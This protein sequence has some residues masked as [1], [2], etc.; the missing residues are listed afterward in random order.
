MPLSFDEARVAAGKTAPQVAPRESGLAPAAD[1]AGVKPLTGGIQFDVAG[2]KDAG[3]SEDEIA[4]AISK[5]ANFD[6]DAAEKAGYS[7]QDIINFLSPTAKGAE[8]GKELATNIKE[9]FGRDPSK[10][11]QLTGVDYFNRAAAGAA[12]GGAVGGALGLVTGPGAIVTGT[13]GAIGGAVS[14]LIEAGLEDLGFGKG[15]Q[16]VGGMVAPGAGLGTKVGQYIE[17]KIADKALEYAAKKVT[18]IP[19]AG[20]AMKALQSRKPV[21]VAALEKLTGIKGST[22]EAKLSTEEATAVKQK[23]ATDFEERT[24]NKIPQGV[25]PEEHIYDLTASE[26]NKANKA[27]KEI[28]A[29]ADVKEITPGMGWGGTETVAKEGTAAIPP[30]KK[31]F[32]GTSFFNR[33]TSIEGEVSA[34]QAR[35]YKSIF[36][37]ARGNNLPGQD[38][39]NNIRAFKY[40]EDLPKT[41]GFLA[42]DKRWE[43]GVKL[44]KE[45]NGWL[46]KESGHAWQA[47]ARAAYEQVAVAS[48]RDKLPSL[49]EGV[50]KAENKTELRAAAGQL[51]DQMWN[52][53]KSPEGQQQFWS[54]LAGNLK[55]LPAK[56]TKVLWQE[57]APTVQ[58]R[59]MKDPE[60]FSTLNDIM[61]NVKTPQDISRAVRVIN[62]LAI[63]GAT[64]GLR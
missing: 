22:A 17:T 4:S 63:A 23:I 47:D 56:D 3:Y 13:A 37:D 50:A 21:D 58:K 41:A 6:K 25:D 54:Q 57:I 34:A 33:A 5:K 52:L 44:E 64:T 18:G 53:S 14:G 36:Q 49:M 42:K 10:A 15:T 45:F 48:A 43:E 31:S 51:E 55:D 62:A 12:T 32:V 8:Q 29:T 28:P 7:P 24:G 38:I 61:S 26:I 30:Q 46:Q 2:A 40:G 20:A 16:F 35:K 19:F 60:K 1:K 11:G 39:I 27:S 59:F 9:D